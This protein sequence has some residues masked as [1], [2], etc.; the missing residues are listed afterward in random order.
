MKEKNKT[1][2][3]IIRVTGKGVGYFTVI[4]GEAD[5]EVQP[6]NLN[7]AL[8]R[9]RVKVASLGKEIFGRKQAKVLEIVE[10][11]KIEFVG[12]FE[13][14]GENFFLVPDDKRM[15]RDIF[16]PLDYARGASGGDK[17][18]VKITE[19]PDSSKSPKGEVVRVIGRAGEHNAEM[20]GIVYESGF[21]VDFPPEVEKEAE[22]WKEKYAKE[23]RLKDRKDF[24]KT[25]TFTIDP[26]DAKDFDDAISIKTLENGN[27]EI[28]VHIADVSHF[29][30]E[31]TELDKTLIE[32]DKRFTYEEAQEILDKGAGT[33]FNELKTLN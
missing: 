4:D 24:S 28:G 15:Y 6:E 14:D 12:T 5:L 16:V 27:Y 18:Q 3:G 30:V 22:A 31:K 2:E 21:E 9:D 19:W 10:R 11:H 25:T 26:A 1:L 32:S 29:V 7:A 20:L 23:D 8:N 17:V 33:F 13:Q